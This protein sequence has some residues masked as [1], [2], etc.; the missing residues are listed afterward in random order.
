MER[1]KT[2]KI[3]GKKIWLFLGIL[4]VATMLFSIGIGRY[5][6]SFSDVISIL[7]GKQEDAMAV[8]VF[9]QLRLPRVCFGLLAG[10]AF[11][12][13]GAVFQLLFHN[14]LASPDLI[15]VSSGASLGAATAICIGTG[16]SFSIMT[17]AF[18]GGILALILVLILVKLTNQ[19]QKE[20]F[21]LAGIAVS[22]LADAC[23]MMLKTLV[24][25]EGELAAIEFWTMGSFATVTATKTIS[26]AVPVVVCL[27]LL[28]LLQKHILVLGL[29]DESAN[30]LGM[31]SKYMRI[32]LLSICTL[33][34]SC[35][36][37]IAGGIAFVGLLAPHIA[38]LLLKRKSN[39]LML[40]SAL[41]GSILVLFADCFARMSMYGELPISIL[42]SLLAVPFLIFFLWKRRSL[43]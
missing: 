1:D 32:F 37:A 41:V 8:Q 17:G 25:T 20:T 30:Y 18:T 16:T 42:T 24:D 11:G 4:L 3:R 22:A 13:I 2:M 34:T 10:S 43:L 38:H 29:G 9:Y 33:A 6:L 26:I 12:M 21:L 36:V 39:G 7:I 28:L 27:L 19:S 35:I 40:M 5:P 31:N 23:I 14:S 15:G